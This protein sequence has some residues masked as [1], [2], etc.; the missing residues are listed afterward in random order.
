MTQ[1]E[2][3]LALGVVGLFI[4]I[5]MNWGFNKY[6]AAVQDRR[7]QVDT[8][9][10]KQLE[11]VESQLQGEYA[12]RQMGQYIDRSLSG[13]IEH[14]QSDYQQW[15][16]DMVHSNQVGNASVDPTN[17]VE[18]ELFH[19]LS[20]RVSGTTDVPNFLSLL[21]QF[22]AKDYLH[23]IRTVEITPNRSQSFVVEMMIDAIALTAVGLDAGDPG[24]D[25]WRVHENFATYQEPIMNRNFFKPPNQAPAYG[26]QSTV[27]AIVGRETPISLTFKDAE[28]NAIEYGLAGEVPDF[29]TLD[30]SSGTLRV[31]SDEK[32]EFK[33][34]VTAKDNGYPSRT[35]EQE[36]LVKIVDPPVAPSPPPEK[37]A[38][39]DASQTV[40]TALVQGGDEW[41]AWMN[42]R[43]R[44]KTLKLR[45]GDEFEIGS[46][47]GKVVSVK[48]KYVELEIEQD[49]RFTLKPAGVL[50][51]AVDRAMED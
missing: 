4:A 27:E 32:R 16:L 33:I 39:D 40:L 49:R 12:N 19:K 9:S 50:R 23:R 1:R 5:G 38:F 45:V 26:G 47:K 43:T 13:N 15:L 17:S 34:L 14:A 44:G 2:R 22:Y 48:P 46:V 30:R 36:L 51:E 20:F 41:T 6:R 24:D 11:L 8:L 42:V 35:T 31:N 10:T 28:G 21:H 25:S 29:V 7:S 37:P 3:M 18:G